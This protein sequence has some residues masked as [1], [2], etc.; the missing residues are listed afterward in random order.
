MDK[1]RA[2]AAF[3][4][5]ARFFVC[6]SVTD[7]PGFGFADRRSAA[8]DSVTNARLM[9]NRLAA[10]FSLL[11]FIA[12]VESLSY[13]L[14]GG[15]RVGLIEG[16]RLG[17]FVLAMTPNYSGTHRTQEFDTNIDINAGRYRE[18]RNFDLKDLDVAFFG[19]SFT[20]GHG[21]NTGDRYTDLFAA[22]FPE[23]KA[24]SLGYAAGLQPEHYEFFFNAHPELTP[25]LGVVGL[26]LG[27]DLESDVN[28][29]VIHK[30]LEGRIIDVSLP[31]R[32]VFEGWPV[33]ASTGR[34]GFVRDLAKHS[35]FV[36]YALSTINHSR[37]RDFLFDPDTV[38]PNT[39][40][41]VE[42]EKGQFGAL[43]FR[44]LDS[45][46]RLQ[47]ELA[48]RGGRLIVLVIPQNYFVTASANLHLNP[49]LLGER[50][51]L[52]HG[53]NIKTAVLNFCARASLI[54]LDPSPVLSESDYFRFDAHWT[55]RGHLTIAK[56]L[57][58]QV[59]M[60]GGITAKH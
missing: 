48:R 16:I 28:E 42:I 37:Y 53:D 60:A 10:I 58:E 27:N 24:A 34:L 38:V 46:S 39:V 56:F 5:D 43:A 57:V 3:P 12:A 20:F 32:D 7:A 23:I 30:S 8:S 11:L 59:T 40:N 14:I 15:T 6:Q 13:L 51:R 55:P 21:V 41:T 17:D 22:A 29:T 49:I 52:I 35:Y 25:K 18:D 36:R 33:N 45:L 31:Y 19:D 47:T 50:E 1:A 54:C 2:T 4:I 9:M 44:A 26:Y